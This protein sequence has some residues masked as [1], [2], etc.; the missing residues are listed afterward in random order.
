[1]AFYDLESGPGLDDESSVSLIDS[2]PELSGLRSGGNA[3]SES[4]TILLSRVS[5]GDREAFDQLI[6]LVYQELHRIAEGYVRRE[7]RNLTLQPTALIHEAY[8][9]LAQS[10]GAGCRIAH[11]FRRCGANLCVLAGQRRAQAAKPGADVKSRS[12]R[13]LTSHRTD[14]IV[15]ALDDAEHLGP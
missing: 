13:V 10:G 3:A 11:T 2:P 6:P 5:G 12:N 14:R 4:I 7:S 1:M 15:L 9:R 8:L